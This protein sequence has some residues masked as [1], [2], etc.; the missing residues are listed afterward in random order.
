MPPAVK[1][2]LEPCAPHLE[3]VVG[4]DALCDQ[5]GRAP[6]QPDGNARAW[7][8]TSFARLPVRGGEFSEDAAYTAG[9]RMP[10]AQNTK[11]S[12][13][14]GSWLVVVDSDAVAC[15]PGASPSPWGTVSPVAPGGEMGSGSHVRK[16]AAALGR[17]FKEVFGAF[18][19]DEGPVEKLLPYTFRYAEMLAFEYGF[20]RNSPRLSC[21]RPRL[22]LF[23]VT[24]P[25]TSVGAARR[26]YRA[27]L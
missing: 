6:A 12:S 4:P 8:V 20:A 15:V 2:P 22:S 9:R 25:K 27:A 21:R 11:T 24:C 3:P 10:S 26:L 5:Y 18:S 7:G 19:A 14:F 1:D 13:G 23:A 16:I 17:M